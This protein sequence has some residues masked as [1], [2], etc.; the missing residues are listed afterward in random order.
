MIQG[1]EKAAAALTPEAAILCGHIAKG[2]ARATRARRDDL[3]WQVTCD[4]DH[5]Q[6]TDDAQVLSLDEAMQAMKR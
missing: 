3:G 2:K 6:D 4:A 5:S 1:I